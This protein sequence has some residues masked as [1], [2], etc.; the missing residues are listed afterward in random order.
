MLKIL[1]LIGRYGLVILFIAAG[2]NHFLNPAFYVSIMPP[3]IPWPLFWVQ[4]SGILEIGLGLM[5]GIPWLWAQRV[6]AW[7]L[8]GLLV[9]VMPVHIHMLLHADQFAQFPVWGLWLRLPMQG[10]LVAWVYVYTRGHQAC[11][12]ESE[13]SEG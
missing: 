1:N 11:S 12:P 9:G 2:I 3:Y 10:I 4:V 5:L 13:A 7:G 8:I 6:A